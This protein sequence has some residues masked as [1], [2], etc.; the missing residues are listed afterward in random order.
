[1]IDGGS[2]LQRLPWKR[3][4]QFSTILDSYVSYVKKRYGKA[5]VVFDGYESGPA[6]KDVTHQ[7]RTG[8]STGVEVKF[9]EDMLLAIKKEIFLANKGNKQRFIN[10]LGQKLED[11]GC[12]V[13][14]SEGDA[15]FDIVKKAVDASANVN[16]VV[17]GDDTDLL[18]LLLYH[19]KKDTHNIFFCP[20]QKQNA[21]KQSK[22]WDI[23][24]CQRVLGS[25][26][27]RCIL[28]L[29]AFL[30]CD[31]TSSIFGIGKGL[32]LKA[33]NKSEQFQECASVFCDEFSSKEQ[34][35]AAGE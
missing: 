10:M 15:D 6:P 32:S 18:P 3:G 31:T 23:Q 27:C 13:H 7:R 24:L 4:D 2:L 20:E 1:M 26:I 22:V 16:T 19:A 28:F 11:E 9:K 14:Y 33:F 17:V 35:C 21:K 29:H 5:V 34:V 30:G 25:K 8:Q 12:E